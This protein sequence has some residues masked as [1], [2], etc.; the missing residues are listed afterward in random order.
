MVFPYASNKT[1]YVEEL[2]RCR[3]V[4]IHVQKCKHTDEQKLGRI[5]VKTS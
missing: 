4:H 3:G 5:I 1:E 2:P